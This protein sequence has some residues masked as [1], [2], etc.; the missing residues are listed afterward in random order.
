MNEGFKAVGVAIA[1]TCIAGCAGIAGRGTADEVQ[2]LEEAQIKD[3]LNVG[4][5]HVSVVGK[6]GPPDRSQEQVAMELRTL[7]KNGAVQLGGNV[8]VEM[9]RVIDGSQ[10]FAVFRCDR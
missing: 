9:T 3:C 1:M 8:I 2:V 10:S 5:T 6:V 4:A 7:G